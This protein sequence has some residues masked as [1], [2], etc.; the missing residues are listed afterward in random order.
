MTGIMDNAITNGKSDKHD[1]DEVLKSLRKVAVDTNKE[2]AE[3]I[4]S[5]EVAASTRERM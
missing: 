2:Y 3:K 5:Q 4:G 1:L